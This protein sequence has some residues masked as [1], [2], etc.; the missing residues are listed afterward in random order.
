MIGRCIN[1]ENKIL[2]WKQDY[3][4]LFQVNERPLLSDIRKIFY[5]AVELSYHGEEILSLKKFIKRVDEWISAYKKV[6]AVTKKKRGPKEKKPIAGVI[7][8]AVPNTIHGY[9]IDKS[10]ENYI[11]LV[12]EAEKMAFSCPELDSLKQTIADIHSFKERASNKLEILAYDYPQTSIAASEVLNELGILVQHGKSFDVDIDE[13]HVVESKLKGLN[14]MVNAGAILNSN[15]ASDCPEHTPALP[16]YST[17]VFWIDKGRNAGV[18]GEN[19]VMAELLRL[20]ALG[21]DWKVE[22]SSLLKRKP[23]SLSDI[24][25]LLESGVK[26]PAPDL[27]KKVKDVARKAEDWRNRFKLTFGIINPSEAVNPETI[28]DTDIIMEEANPISTSSSTNPGNLITETITEANPINPPPISQE[29]PITQHTPQRHISPPPKLFNPNVKQA[30]DYTLVANFLDEITQISV[31]ELEEIEYLNAWLEEVEEWR[32]RAKRI[33]SPT[34]QSSLN[35]I[36][37]EL[38]AVVKACTSADKGGE[39]D[40]NDDEKYCICH[41]KDSVGFMVCLFLLYF[42]LYF[43]YQI[44]CDVCKVWYHGSCLN[45]TEQEADDRFVCLVCDVKTPV[46]RPKS[47]DISTLETVVADASS[48]ICIPDE[49]KMI[50][51]IFE[52]LL[53]WKRMVDVVMKELGSITE[54]LI[55]EY[56]K[57]LKNILRSIEGLPFAYEEER[58]KLRVIIGI[59]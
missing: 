56:E 57:K 42:I 37:K 10:L 51:E 14:W 43:F 39:A 54:E 34:S 21:D 17:L 45:I 3:W 52:M 41:R 58:E 31:T 50:L 29:N 9:A 2:D 53:N 8:L 40:G 7:I 20:K 46:D 25:K 6:L 30:F 24:T 5:R 23:Y 1:E 55:P 47:F 27:L 32:V 35:D 15:A 22:A 49:K 16:D 12:H 38:L 36:V 28:A 4:S 19:P 26:V 48:I 18:R 13:I 33:L 11:K 44:E 59:Y